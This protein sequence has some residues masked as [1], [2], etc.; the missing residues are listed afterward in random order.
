MKSKILNKLLLILAQL[1]IGLNLAFANDA[2][3]PPIFVGEKN[4]PIVVKEYFSLTCSH[5]SSFHEN[6]FPKFK[7]ELIDTGKVKFEFIDY[8]LDRLAMF[9]ASLARS[10]PS[11]SYVETISLLLSNQKKWAYSKDPVTE[12]LKLS[13]LFGISEKKFNQILNNKELMEKILK[14]M[15][16][17]NSRFNISSTPTFVINDK[18]VIAGSLKYNEFVKKLK[19]FE[20]LN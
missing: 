14:K 17:E 13:K 16:E 9:A 7:K 8:P 20:L 19:D 15:E 10:I 11:E 12:L 6:T 18:H 5:C 2:K 4:A 3:L 1:F